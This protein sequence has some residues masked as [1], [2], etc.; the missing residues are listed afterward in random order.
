MNAD[1]AIDVSFLVA[2]TSKAPFRGI[3]TALSRKASRYGTASDTWSSRIV[4][5]LPTL[6]AS[7]V[8]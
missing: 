7:C 8:T 6:P 2:E 4:P 5:T 3:F 1:A